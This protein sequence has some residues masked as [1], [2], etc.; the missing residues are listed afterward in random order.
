MSSQSSMGMRGA[1]GNPA[2]RNIFSFLNDIWQQWNIQT[3]VLAS[4]AFQIVLIFAAP[5]RTRAKGSFRVVTLWSVYLLADYIATYAIGL[6]NNG[7]QIQGTNDEATEACGSFKHMELAPLWAPFL[8]LHLGGPDTITAFAIEDN[9]LWLRHLLSLFVQL[10]SVLLVFYRYRIHKSRFLI[11]TGL[12]FIAGVIKYAERTRSLNLASLA[13]LKKSMREEPDAGPDYAQLMEE[14][15]SKQAANLPVTIDINREKGAKAD[16]MD[17]VV[18]MTQK[19][20]ALEELEVIKHG[21]K[22][23]RVFKGLIVD[24]MFSFLERDE[25][26]RF[27][28]SLEFKDAFRVMEMELNFIYDAMFT[29]LSAVRSIFGYIFRFICTA[30]L[31]SATVTFS[32]SLKNSPHHIHPGDIIVTYFLLGGGVAL[33]LI[34]IM[35]LIF[36]KWTIAALLVDSEKSVTASTSAR[37]WRKTVA[38]GI[39]RVKGIIPTKRWSEEMH[40]YS[41]INHCLH[42]WPDWVTYLI[43][44][45]GLTEMVCSCLYGKTR[46]VDERLKMIIFEEI[47]KKGKQATKTSVAKEISSSKGEWTL[48]DYN[49]GP[50][51]HFSVSQDVDYDECVL[52][53]HIATEIFYFSNSKAKTRD[54]EAA[55][56]SVENNPQ[57]PQKK[58]EENAGDSSSK[59]D[60]DVHDA[61]I[62][63]YISEYLLYLLVIER[64]MTA[65]VAGIVEIRFRDTCKEATNFFSRQPKQKKAEG[66]SCFSSCCHFLHETFKNVKKS[67]RLYLYSMVLSTWE[68]IKYVFT[69]KCFT[70]KVRK[71]KP[72]KWEEEQNRLEDKKRKEAC[73]NLKSVNPQVRPSEVKGDRSKSLLFDACILAAHLERLCKSNDFTENRVWEMM[74]RVWVELLSYGACHCRGDAH[75]QYLGKGGELLT[76]AW[77][78]MAHFG[79]GEQFRIE[80]GHARAKL[81]VGKEDIN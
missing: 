71:R 45:V 6:I 56:K 54:I 31:V 9:E 2:N 17:D 80:A 24:H 18:D 21:Y 23:F 26:R 77:L 58:Q 76:F 1:D 68:D 63:R 65:A 67:C 61:E 4:L 64:K 78:L 32:L 60:N 57:Q 41:F 10:F 16:D 74:S 62:C 25:S 13:N 14:M 69:L 59:Q 48:L 79:L 42:K 75:A 46:D 53:W 37:N 19:Y 3:I 52:L 34:A 33:D 50:E 44:Q 11:P 8:L 39:K 70:E 47:K 5:T 30:L 22:F 51:I 27:Y 66:G 72:T 38:K 35:E 73:E 49:C 7:S 15:S 55:A 12:T 29:K 81:I 43:D 28:R 40:Q 20:Q 36:S